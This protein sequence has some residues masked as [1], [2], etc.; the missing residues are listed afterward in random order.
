MS[1]T[2]PTNAEFLALKATVASLATVNAAEDT[3]L[4]LAE[5]RLTALEAVPP[6]IVPPVLPPV[7]VPPVGVVPDPLRLPTASGQ[8]LNV[9]AYTALNVPALL[10]GA[11]YVDP[12]SGVTIVKL[13]T[14]AAP[15]AAGSYASAVDYGSGGC[16]I[17]RPTNGVYPIV[18]ETNV[19]TAAQFHLITFNPTTRAVGYRSPCPG[20]QRELCRAFS[21]VTPNIL[22]AISGNATIRKYD[23]SGTTPVE[24]TGGVWPKDLS[25]HLHGQSRFGWFQQTADDRVFCMMAGDAGS[26]VVLWDSVTDTVQDHDF[27]SFDEPKLSKDGRYVYSTGH[28]VVWDAV[29][30]I[31]RPVANIPGHYTG[32]C[33]TLRQYAFGFDGDDAQGFWRIDL[34]S[35]SPALVPVDTSY[36]L[37]NLYTSGGWVDQPSDLTQWACLGYQPYVGPDFPN[38]KLARSGIGLERLDGSGGL[39]LLCHSYGLGNVN[40]TSDY[41]HNSLWPN[42]APDGT[43][44]LFKSNMNVLGGFASLFAALL[45]QPSIL[46]PV[47]VPPPV[48]VPPP[49]PPLVTAVWPHEPAGLTTLHATGWEDGTLGPWTVYNQEPSKVIRIVPVTDSP[50]GEK[51]VL[52]IAYA[53]GHQGG[54]GA[55]ARLELGAARPTE[56][57]VGYYVQVNPLWQGHSSG[58]NKMVFLADGA[59]DGTF[60]AIWYEMYGFGQSPLGLYVV[61]QSAGGAG[62]VDARSLSLFARGIWHQVEIYQRQ[63]QPGLLQV[64]VDGVLVL[65]RPDV[66]TRVAPFDAVAISGI[67]GGVGDSKAQ[68]DFMRFDRIRVS[69]R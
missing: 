52:E 15:V 3:R 58:I 11:S 61:N 24:I 12:A 17:G 42:M 28:G 44:C 66:V 18:I 29:N 5:A 20:D 54:G 51:N 46:P 37:G 68:N 65:N 6:V 22:Y 16:R 48:I 9:P 33:D 47:V 8:A 38:Q 32:H 56:L 49:A 23:V 4:T 27:V 50:I 19:E 62:Y 41:Y 25:A 69:G 59:Q 7:P 30:D 31:E 45:P 40:T 64:W 43:F 53:A 26:W 67:W 2:V 39:R 35:A 63:G 55:E 14:P 10:P 57:F 60:S 1:A 21:L 34:E 13:T 36:Y